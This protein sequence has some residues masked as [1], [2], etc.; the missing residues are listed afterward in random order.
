MTRRVLL[1]DD[2][3][4]VREALGQTLEL[5]DLDALTA[6]SFVEA[7]DQITPDFEGIIVSD[8]RMPGRDGFHLLSY[9]REMDADLPVILLTGEGDIPM[10]VSAMGKGAFDF[11]EKPCAPKELI[12]VI[13]RALKTR[14]LVLENR[15]LKA[16]LET[17]DPAARMLFGTS[18]LA[19]GLRSRV[20]S[21][22]RTRAEV[23][24]SGL[25]GVG[26]SKVAEV[27]HLCSPLSKGPFGKHAAVGMDSSRFTEAAHNATG[28]SL[29]LDE[30]TTMPME[31]QFALLALMEQGD[32]PRLI[33]GS[34][35]DLARAVEQGLLHA[36]LFYRLDAMQVRIPSLAERPED[37]PVLFRQYVA[38]AAEQSGIKP[39]EI[40]SELL[41][42]L[43]ARD[44]P[45]NARALMS[46]AMRFVLG[47]QDGDAQEVA[48]LGLAEQMAQVERSLLQ[49]A[50]RRAEGRASAAAKAL[51]LPRKT[52]YDKLAKHGVKPEDF[53]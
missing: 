19:E 43:M 14:A 18:G 42:D 33:F 53:R 51:K 40:H 13:E 4:A 50:L 12:A 5:A 2:D 37:I 47:L 28:G 7:K 9:A 27:V 21:V 44:W 29:F 34:T 39:P 24:V 49:E 48:T 35:A 1:V 26:I 10:A 11:L 3:I 36:D 45:G 32:H 38:Q 6:G 23:L 52:F 30:I 17:G 31:T 41:A 46:V 15:R 8:I 22:A 16:Q 25:P 20:R